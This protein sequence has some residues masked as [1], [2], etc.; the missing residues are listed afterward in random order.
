MVEF[1]SRVLPRNISLDDVQRRM[2]ISPPEEQRGAASSED[3]VAVVPADPASMAEL[4]QIFEDD[5]GEALSLSNHS[6]GAPRS[7]TRP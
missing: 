4:L 3:Q 6:S 2:G 5:A 1:L 7:R